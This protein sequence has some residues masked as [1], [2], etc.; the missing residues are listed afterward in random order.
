[1]A[2]YRSI[3]F[4]EGKSEIM[5]LFF[6]G[7]PSCEL[8]FFWKLKEETDEAVDS[9]LLLE[10]FQNLGNYSFKVILMIDQMAS[11]HVLPML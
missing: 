11:I 9:T 3:D 8:P 6:G 4:K 5:R 7:K 10:K 1:M 2:E